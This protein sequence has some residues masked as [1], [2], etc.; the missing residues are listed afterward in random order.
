MGCK[1]L[2]KVKYLPDG[3]VDRYKAKL[4]AKGFTQ[5]ANMDYFETFAPIAKMTSFRLL[6]ALAVMNNWNI[7]QLDFSNAFLHGTLEEEAYMTC[8]VGYSI[9]EHILKKNILIK[10]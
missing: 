10:S 1:W 8:T 7:M 3:K 6:L 4:V 9:P 2:Y 5:I